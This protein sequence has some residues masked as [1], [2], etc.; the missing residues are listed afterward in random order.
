MAQEIPVPVPENQV[1]ELSS[2]MVKGAGAT[3]LTV[4]AA[5]FVN[6]GISFVLDYVDRRVDE[7]AVIVPLVASA[8]IMAAGKRMMDFAEQRGMQANNISIVDRINSGELSPS[9]VDIKVE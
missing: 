2:D 3:L 1:K 6:Y 7:P 4:G 8:M 9:E 5:A